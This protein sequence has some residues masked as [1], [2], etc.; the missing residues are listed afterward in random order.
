MVCLGNI[1]RS[2]LAEGILKNK[3][4]PEKVFVDSAGTGGYH[5]GLKPDSRSIDVAQK[6]GIDIKDQ[7]CRKFSIADFEEFDM[8]YVMDKSNYQNI[9]NLAYT[10]AD[11]QKVQLLLE[12]LG[13]GSKEVP[14][15]Y[16]DKADGFEKVFHMI[17]EACTSIA[18]DL[19]TQE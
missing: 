19:N 13:E 9:I 5:I 12:V 10:E 15:P 6:Y 8:I 7:R 18:N 14:D 17:D 11:K 1:C 2:P 16:H 3:V 4:A